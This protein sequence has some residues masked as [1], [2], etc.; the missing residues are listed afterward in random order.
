MSLTSKRILVTGG[1]G[2]VGSHL[3]ER[4][5]ESGH[6][7]QGDTART[8]LGRR[9]A[10]GVQGKKRQRRRCGAIVKLAR[11]GHGRRERGPLGDRLAGRAG[12]K[13]GGEGLPFVD[14]YFTGRRL[15]VA[16]L[17]GSPRFE[18]PA[19]EVAR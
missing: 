9:R 2:F 19:A 1:A 18:T 4:L 8:G 10:H 6:D 17:Q 5:L 16:H 11:R 14:N 7:V 15:N 12:P 3:C 13:R